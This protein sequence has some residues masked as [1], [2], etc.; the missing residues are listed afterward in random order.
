MPIHRYLQQNG[1][2]RFEGRIF[3]TA[4]TITIEIA[5]LEV[6]LDEVETRRLDL[7]VD[8]SRRRTMSRGPVLIQYEGRRDAAIVCATYH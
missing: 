2:L 5:D 6:V 4:E 1:H 8:A 3:M 7:P